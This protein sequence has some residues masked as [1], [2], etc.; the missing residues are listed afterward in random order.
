MTSFS[1]RNLEIRRTGPDEPWRKCWTRIAEILETKERR[2]G[3]G[4]DGRDMS[5]TGS[6]IAGQTGSR[7]NCISTLF[8]EADVNLVG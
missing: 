5:S 8:K 2:G 4:H 7:Q 1:L 6:N 3:V